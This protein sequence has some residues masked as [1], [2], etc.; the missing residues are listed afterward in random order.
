L[1]YSQIWL[2]LLWI[3]TIL[4]TSQNWKKDPTSHI[5]GKMQMYDEKSM[6][7]FHYSW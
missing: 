7:N 1:G 5:D 2:N 6:Q 3:I 4:A